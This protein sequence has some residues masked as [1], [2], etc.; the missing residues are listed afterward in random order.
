MSFNL[1]QTLKSVLG[2]IYTYNPLKIKV[3]LFNWMTYL[4][5]LEVVSFTVAHSNDLSE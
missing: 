5:L 1:L 3:Y 2:P 4:N